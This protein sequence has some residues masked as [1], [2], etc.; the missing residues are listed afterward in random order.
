M[1]DG[2]P[3][4]A[5]SSAGTYIRNTMLLTTLFL[6]LPA[7]QQPYPLMEVGDTIGGTVE[8]PLRF[9]KYI[10]NNQGSWRAQCTWTGGVNEYVIIQNGDLLMDWRQQLL[11][12][13]G[14]ARWNSLEGWEMNNRGEVVQSL[15]FTGNPGGLTDNEGFYYEDQH[16]LQ[17]EGDL[18]LDP[19]APAGAVWVDWR[20]VRFAEGGF[21]LTQGVY[22]E[23]SVG[24]VECLVMVGVAPD[25]TPS[26]V[27]IIR[28][29]AGDLL[30]GA[31]IASFRTD[32]QS[33]DMN[34]S[35]DL[36]HY[37]LLASG[38]SATNTI[39]MLND[40]VL[41]REG[42][43][44]PLAG[45]NYG[46]LG[47]S[48]VS[49]NNLGH[50]AF[51]ASFGNTTV[52]YGLIVDGTVVHKYGDSLPDIAPYALNR[53]T[54]GNVDIADTGDVLW[55][56]QFSDPNT[57]TDEALFLNDR[58]LVREGVTE[59]HGSK[60]D[61]IDVSL[62]A[63]FITDN[64]RQ[65]MFEAILE[66]GSEGLYAIDLDPGLR[67]LP[68]TPAEA[69]RFNTVTVVNAD[70]GADVL[71]GGS[72]SQGS[73]SVPCPGGSSLQLELGVPAWKLALLHADENGIAKRKVMIRGSYFGSTWYL[74][75]LDRASCVASNLETV[76]FQ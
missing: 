64:G 2:V 37:A 20:N 3:G 24:E 65:V 32:H 75:A 47:T 35:G 39:L 30:D 31:P 43:P 76:T 66:D 56:G 73:F 53:V 45:I 71:L 46:S 63:F 74:Q 10:I 16:L 13:P 21:A 17:L 12:G 44:S 4:E 38:S 62:W 69:G 25:G 54:L 6:L 57:D 59:I 36:I 14:A 49:V 61:V 70:P 67:L 18:V 68:V 51:N 11:G 42:S 52:R 33:A 58:V 15:Q 8:S 19:S 1:D 27:E 29:Q 9:D 50:Y 41:A 28:V 60:V 55:Y 5:E 23:A 22:H 72:R 34:A 48:S 7:A 40:T 26:D